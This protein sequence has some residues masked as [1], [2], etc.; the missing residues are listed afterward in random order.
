[1]FKIINTFVNYLTYKKGRKIIL[2]R[3]V[4]F[5][6]FRILDLKNYSWK[7]LKNFSS[8][9]LTNL[10]KLKLSNF[11]YKLKLKTGVLKPGSRYYIKRDISVETFFERLFDKRYVLLRWFDQYPTLSKTEDYDILISD[12]EFNFA[13]KQCVP[14]PNGGQPIDFYTPKGL[15]GANYNGTTY[16]P[17][18]LAEEI[19]NNSELYKKKVR[20]PNNKYHLLSLAYHIVFH[21][22][23][24]S[25]IT[26]N[27]EE[28]KII[29]HDYLDIINNLKKK[30][31]YKYNFYDLNTIYNFLQKKQWIPNA[32]SFNILSR[33]NRYIRELEKIKFNTIDKSKGELIVFIIRE[34]AALNNFIDEIKRTVFNNGISIIEYKDLNKKE[35]AFAKKNFRGGYWGRGNFIKSGGVP[36]SMLI[37]F[38]YCPNISC[39]D[40]SKTD[41]N[42]LILKNLIRN[43][44]NKNQFFFNQANI[45][46]S[47]DNEIE[48]L[49]YIKKIDSN[50]Y[51]K[52]NRKL[53]LIRETDYFDNKK[54]LRVINPNGLRS[55][56]SVIK[57]NNKLCIQKKFKLNMKKFLDKEVYAYS[58]LSQ[59]LNSIPKLIEKGENFLIIEYFE[60]IL[61]GL[62]ENSS[63]EV[64]KKYTWDI[65]E[66]VYSLWKIGYAHIDLNPNNIIITRNGEL[67]ICDFEFLYK[68][69]DQNIP[70]SESYDF[71]GV[72]LNFNSDLPGYYRRR[73][74]IKKWDGYFCKKQLKK[75]LKD[76][77]IKNF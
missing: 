32:E 9:F 70:F 67:K 60:N 8:L 53:N 5:I 65:L 24:D 16:F 15:N 62:S 36:F 22:G 43:K 48:S 39:I 56:V 71:K 34:Y 72:P 27:Q 4:N 28:I 35:V 12:K 41:S 20:V 58:I 52:I 47:T 2:I 23:Y 51:S 31:N 76:K 59:K 37:C 17:T 68:Y 50:L 63:K 13:I 14:Y 7:I 55:K 11:I 75:F 73:S 66:I 6:Y 42:I 38:D 74:L 64:I 77:C 40:S 25:G 29:D 45:I 3:L 46:H 19:L 10:I 30:L 61:E 44:I 1:M 18:N 21:K 54:D 49:E 33:Y 57:Y 69:K 26:K